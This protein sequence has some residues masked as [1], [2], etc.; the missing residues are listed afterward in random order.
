[1]AILPIIRLALFGTVLVFSIIVLGLAGNTISL[2]NGNI[3]NQ[4]TYAPLAVA[5]SVIT[6]VV[7]T[8]MII[9][10][11]LR[12]GAITSWLM[13]EMIICVVIGI[14]WLATAADA[15]GSDVSE[16]FSGSCD[17]IGTAK[18]VSELQTACHSWQAIQAFGYLN[19]IFLKAYA[20]LLLILAVIQNSR[21]N[22]GIWQTPVSEV[23]FFGGGNSASSGPPMTDKMGEPTTADHSYPPQN[24]PQ[25][26]PQQAYTPPP[27]GGIQV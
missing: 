3:P 13:V 5:I 15:S 25:N 24:S 14:L 9:V 20:T 26:Y 17:F 16:S 21:G 7:L 22:K 12:R 27:Q 2:L 10:E 1:M 8:P 6:L 4:F 18:A 19:W 23:P 11:F